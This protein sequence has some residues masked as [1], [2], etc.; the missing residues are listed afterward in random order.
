MDFGVIHGCVH[1][2]PQRHKLVHIQRQDESPFSRVVNHLTTRRPDE[3]L[4]W[5]PAQ[6]KTRHAFRVQSRKSSCVTVSG[7][8]RY[9]ALPGEGKRGT[10]YGASMKWRLLAE[11]G[12]RVVCNKGAGGWSWI[13]EASECCFAEAVRLPPPS[14]QPRYRT[15]YGGSFTCHF[16]RDDIGTGKQTADIEHFG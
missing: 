1:V 4:D 8:C 7:C 6:R 11:D 3:A 13:Y 15:D 16:G 5:L 2:L 12:W 14:Y 10:Y 9:I